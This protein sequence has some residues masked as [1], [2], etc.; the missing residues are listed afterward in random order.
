[1]FVKV[2]IFFWGDAK[3]LVEMEFNKQGNIFLVKAD[4]TWIPSTCERC[5]CLGNKEKRCL[6][7]LKTPE[8]SILVS[9]SVAISDDVPIVDIDIIIQ[10]NENSAS[11]TS[12]FQQKELSDQERLPS[13]NLAYEAPTIQ[14][15]FVNWMVFLSLLNRKN[16][17]LLKLLQA[18]LRV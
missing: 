15:Q 13:A 2:I 6:Q 18:R 11:S 5:G 4:Y 14:N 8:N 17:P 7:P 9:N 1:M 12:T 10:H 16:S 3:V